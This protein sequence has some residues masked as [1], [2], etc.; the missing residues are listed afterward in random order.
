MYSELQRLHTCVFLCSIQGVNPHSD[1]VDRNQF[2]SLYLIKNVS[3]DILAPGDFVHCVIILLTVYL[4]TNTH[5][6]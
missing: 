1:T 3:W 5:A 2:A 6:H 4:E